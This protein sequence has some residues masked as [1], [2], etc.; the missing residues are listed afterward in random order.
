MATTG[1]EGARAPELATARLI[2]RP[3]VQDDWRDVYALSVDN[4]VARWT[5]SLPHPMTEQHAR[6]W[7]ESRTHVITPTGIGHVFAVTEKDD[8]CLVGVAGFH[9]RSGTSSADLGYWFGKAY[10][11]RGY[12]TEALVA[13]LRFAFEDLQV[14]EAKATAFPDNI[15][16]MRVLEKAGFRVTGRTNRDIPLRGGVREIVLCAVDKAA[17]AIAGKPA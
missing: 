8:S 2:L 1:A 4:E 7:V 6:S 5:A 15:A 11:N 10:W 16:S 13:M 14:S 3:L 9:V 17:F 12:A